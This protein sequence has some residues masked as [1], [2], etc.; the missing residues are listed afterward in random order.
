MKNAVM[1]KGKDVY[2]M[3]E[4]VLVARGDLPNV[5]VAAAGSAEKGVIQFSWEDNSGLGKAGKKDKAILV[6]RRNEP[7]GFTYTLDA[8]FRSDGG[9]SIRVDTF[10]DCEVHTWLAFLSR[11]RKDITN[12]VFTG[13]LVVA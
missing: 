3:C 10:S 1:V 5:K 6:V 2:I 8:G 13:R 9:A 4:E 12:S 11:D 7:K